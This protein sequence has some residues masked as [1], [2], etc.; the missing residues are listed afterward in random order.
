MLAVGR[1][2]VGVPLAGDVEAVSRGAAVGALI[3]RERRAAERTDKEAR[4]AGFAS[5]AARSSAANAR[6][7]AAFSPS[8]NGAL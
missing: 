6:A 4:H 3:A 1:E 5:I 7:C 8:M 2:E